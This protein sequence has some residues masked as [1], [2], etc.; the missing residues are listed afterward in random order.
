MDQYSILHASFYLTKLSDIYCLCA[1]LNV[2]S[3]TTALA[4][5]TET[6]AKHYSTVPIIKFEAP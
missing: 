1:K 5:A 4:E 6:Y 3:C 2:P